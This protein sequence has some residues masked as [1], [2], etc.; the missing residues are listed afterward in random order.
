MIRVQNMKIDL[1]D[2]LCVQINF[3]PV[4]VDFLVKILENRPLSWNFMFESEFST[5]KSC[6]WVNIKHKDRHSLKSENDEV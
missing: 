6:N 5:L 4:N 2:K 1:T 3:Q